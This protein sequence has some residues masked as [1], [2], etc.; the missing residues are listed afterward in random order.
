MISDE[1]SVVMHGP[2][3]WRLAKVRAANKLKKER[4]S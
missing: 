3:I 1:R 4:G 2:V